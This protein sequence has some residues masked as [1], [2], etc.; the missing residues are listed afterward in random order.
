MGS[1]GGEGGTATVIVATSSGLVITW[2]AYAVWVA[3]GHSPASHS[4]GAPA[5]SPRFSPAQARV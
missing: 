2:P 3:Q 4:W 1:Q 5:P